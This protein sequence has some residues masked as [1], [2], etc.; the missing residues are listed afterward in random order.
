V[1]RPGGVGIVTGLRREAACFRR[2]TGGARV[3]CYGA[4]AEAARRAARHLVQT[5]CRGLVSFGFAGSLSPR[6][7]A[8]TLI[9][10]EAVLTLDGARFPAD[11]PWRRRILVVTGDAV[12]APIVGVDA[13]AAS[14]AEK[15]SLAQFTGAIGADMES[16]A[17]AGVAREAGVPY[18]AVRAVSDRATDSIPA[19]L[20]RTLDARGDVAPLAFGAALLRDPRRLATVLTLFSGTRKALARLR[21][22]TIDG[23]PLFHL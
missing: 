9:V 11:E 1:S 10:P 3:V 17:V 19:W 2:L 23:S 5:G 4:G 22:L 18:I 21:P 7:P 8:G 20:L 6:L 15:A 13:V 12:T 14:P 16:H